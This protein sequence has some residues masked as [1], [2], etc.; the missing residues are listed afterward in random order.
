MAIDPKD[1]QPSFASVDQLLES[2]AERIDDL[3]ALIGRMADALSGFQ[4]RTNVPDFH[5]VEALLS[6]AHLACYHRT[7]PART[8]HGG[9]IYR[10]PR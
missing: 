3:Q 2:H 4:Y 7:P 9:Y 5:E 8:S 1:L 6:E 10:G